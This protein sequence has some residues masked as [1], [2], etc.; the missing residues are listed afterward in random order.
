MSNTV[1]NKVNLSPR[2]SAPLRLCESSSKKFPRASARFSSSL[3]WCSCGSWLKKSYHAELAKA[4]RNPRPFQI[5]SHPP[6]LRASVRALPENFSSS[7]CLRESSSKEFP[8]VFAPLREL[9]QRISPRLRAFVRS[10][11]RAFFASA[12]RDAS[13]GSWLFFVLFFLFALPLSAQTAAEMDG[14]L[15][16]KTV[17]VSAASRFILGAADLLPAGLSAAEAEKSAFDMA[18]SKGWIKRGAGENVTLKETAFL[19]MKAFGFKGG[20]MYSIFRNPRY[21]YRELCYRKII[22]G[23][24]DPGMYVSGERLLQI[25]GRTLSRTGEDKLPDSGF[26]EVLPDGGGL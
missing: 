5:T 26:S 13:C 3:S 10:N 15:N 1:F 7:P 18:M 21:A 4:Q 2:V 12:V 17:T 11:S 23:R 22:Q 6:C 14:L 8:R 9:L 19:L 20:A 25:I 24:A 16:A